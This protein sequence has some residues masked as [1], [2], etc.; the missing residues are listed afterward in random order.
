[1]PT[2][3][4]VPDGYLATPRLEQLRKR[5]Q[6]LSAAGDWASLLALRA[7][8]EQDSRYWQDLWGPLCAIAAR[9]TGDPGAIGLLEDLVQAGF[10]QPQLLGGELESVFC[11]DPVWPR[12]LNRMAGYAPAAPL[13]LTEWP[14]ITPAAPLGL[15]DLPHRAGELRALA[16]SP[17]ASAW[18]TALATLD[19][20]THLWQG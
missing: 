14:V 7:D 10:C 2:F 8:L 16:P 11:E 13:V 20:V 9:R 3:R 15:L 12:L 18:Q 19:W 5:A 17:L 6:D 4:L 1:M